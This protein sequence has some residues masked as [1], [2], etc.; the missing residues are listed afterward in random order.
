[1]LQL[2]TFKW[3]SK[4]KPLVEG[5][6]CGGHPDLLDASYDKSVK[7]QTQL[8]PYL[9]PSA[10]DFVNDAS[11]SMTNKVSKKAFLSSV[12]KMDFMHIFTSWA[13]VSKQHQPKYVRWRNQI[14]VNI[15]LFYN[16]L[17]KV[18]SFH[19]YPLECLQSLTHYNFELVFCIYNNLRSLHSSGPVFSIFSIRFSHLKTK[20]LFYKSTNEC[21]Q[22]NSYSHHI[23]QPFVHL[24]LIGWI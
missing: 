10:I 1:M 18:N 11:G 3:I 14:F 20:K 17:F 19:K 4:Y 7:L 24:L 13:A 23:Y 8:G 16:Y 6:A 21:I 15:Y 5:T 9:T 12:F 22:Y 2:L